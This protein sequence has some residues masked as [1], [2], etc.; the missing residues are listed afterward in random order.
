MSVFQTVSLILLF[1]TFLIVLL[2]YINK[3]YQ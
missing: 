2:N 3:H 1:G